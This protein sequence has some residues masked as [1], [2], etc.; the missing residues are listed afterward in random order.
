ML[1]ICPLFFSQSRVRDDEGEKTLFTTFC[2][3]DRFIVI[4]LT[5]HFHVCLFIFRHFSCYVTGV[6]SFPRLLFIYMSFLLILTSCGSWVRSGICSNSVLKSFLSGILITPRH[7]LNCFFPLFL[8][9]TFSIC[10]SHCLSLF[11]SHCLSVTDSDSL[12][13]L[14]LTLPLHCFGLS[15]AVLSL[16]FQ[17]SSLSWTRQID[18]T[19]LGMTQTSI[20]S[21]NKLLFSLLSSL[22]FS[23]L[24]SSFFPPRESLVL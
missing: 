17:L 12:I 24:F 20:D 18:S 10:H 23:S 22:L 2:H 21:I 9:S 7:E 19:R 11:L 6:D 3:S 1:P 5:G 16:M 14:N 13:L 4:C 15:C 8:P